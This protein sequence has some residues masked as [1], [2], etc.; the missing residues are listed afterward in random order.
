MGNKGRSR[1]K[2]LQTS[3]FAMSSTDGGPE[4]RNAADPATAGDLERDLLAVK[5]DIES[6]TVQITEALN[7]LFGN[8]RKQAKSG[9]KQAG[10]KADSR[11]SDAL[12]PGDAIT[13]AAYSIEETPKDVITGRPLAAVGIALGLGFLI[14]MTWRR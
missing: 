9:S 14:G 6:L 1:N 5:N 10:A 4:A 3:E 11:I 13:D 12:D 7:A 2:L 8:T